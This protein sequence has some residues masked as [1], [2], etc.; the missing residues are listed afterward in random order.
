MLLLLLLLLLL[1]LLYYYYYS[2][3]YYY[4]Y[5]ITIK[6]EHFIAH[7]LELYSQ[8]FTNGLI[9]SLSTLRQIKL[10]FFQIFHILLTVGLHSSFYCIFVFFSCKQMCE[11]LLRALHQL[12][13]TIINYLQ[14]L[15]RFSLT[16][17]SIISIAGVCVCM[18]VSF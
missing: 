6:S 4:Y 8:L 11:L 2:Y 5:Y 13:L 18:C 3:S 16:V 12:L 9:S 14:L 17:W 1:V 15:N 10:Y 7:F